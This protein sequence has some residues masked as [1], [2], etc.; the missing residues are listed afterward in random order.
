[1]VC[2][3]TLMIMV[4]HQN[5]KIDYKNYNNTFMNYYNN[6]IDYNKNKNYI[7]RSINFNIICH[8]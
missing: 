8:L 2:F 7:F 6:N 1:M 4:M 3:N 5:L